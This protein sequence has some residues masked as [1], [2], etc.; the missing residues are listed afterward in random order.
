MESQPV[1]SEPVVESQPEVSADG[2]AASCGS[3]EVESAMAELYLP[4][5]TVPA[6]C[7][8]AERPT[9]RNAML[10]LMVLLAVKRER[11]FGD[12]RV[13]AAAR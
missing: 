1:E 12:N 2:A 3:G 11:D 13:T 7:L 5:V 4:P 9:S 8:A 10:A 6:R